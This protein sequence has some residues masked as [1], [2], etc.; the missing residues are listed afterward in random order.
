MMK[1][2]EGSDRHPTTN[3]DP[4]GGQRKEM[5]SAA[6]RVSAPFRPCA[7]RQ[8]CSEN[9]SAPAPSENWCSSSDSLLSYGHS[10]RSSGLRS[11]PSLPWVC[12]L[13][14]ARSIP[15]QRSSVA[16]VFRLRSAAI[17]RAALAEA[18]APFPG[19]RPTNLMPANSIDQSRRPADFTARATRAAPI[20]RAAMA[21]TKDGRRGVGVM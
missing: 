6:A 4:P 20:P 3:R 9:L 7:S 2:H 11:S 21:A 17:F 8:A 10:S 19:F 12:R 15:H 16:M 5:Q 14:L 1:E 13:N 18:C